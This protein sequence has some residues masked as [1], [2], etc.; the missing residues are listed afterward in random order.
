V[1]P[2]CRLAANPRACVEST[3]AAPS[4]IITL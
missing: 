3:Q 1:S 4:P 2:L